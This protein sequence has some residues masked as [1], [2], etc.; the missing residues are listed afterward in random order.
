MSMRIIKIMLC[1]A[2]VLMTMIMGSCCEPEE[3]WT[4]GNHAKFSVQ[5]INTYIKNNETVVEEAQIG[6]FQGIYIASDD[7]VDVTSF[8]NRDWAFSERPGLT[9]YFVP[10]FEGLDEYPLSERW[11]FAAAS[12]VLNEQWMSSHDW[13][14]N[15][16][17]DCVVNPDLWKLYDLDKFVEWYGPLNAQGWDEVW[18]KW[19]ESKR[20]GEVETEMAAFLPLCCE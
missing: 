17:E 2:F 20:T 13:H 8:L 5:V 14:I 10:C 18:S 1:S 16:P 15:F 6:P 12:I 19:E 11:K 3:M 4:I 7:V 9:L